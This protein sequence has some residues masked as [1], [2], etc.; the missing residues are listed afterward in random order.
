MPYGGA[1]IH[2]DTIMD[3]FGGVRPISVATVFRR[4]SR[5]GRC[6]MTTITTV[7]GT[8]YYMLLHA[9]PHKYGSVGPRN[10]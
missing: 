9:F 4:Q 7:R 1:P 3:R 10:A 8:H 2:P 5:H 6:M